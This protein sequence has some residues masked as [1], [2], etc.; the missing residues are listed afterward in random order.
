LKKNVGDIDAFLRITLGFAG[1]AWSISKMSRNR[2]DQSAPVATLLSAMK[3][4][5]GIVRFCPLSALLGIS[6]TN[7]RIHKVNREHLSP[8]TNDHEQHEQY[9]QT[10]TQ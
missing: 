8:Y 4:A 5:E 3:I 7:N 9:N 6:T 1:L 10:F 2:Y